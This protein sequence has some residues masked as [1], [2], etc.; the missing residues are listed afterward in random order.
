MFYCMPLWMVNGSG[1]IQSEGSERRHS[2]L[3][4]MSDGS[5]RNLVQIC[6]QPHKCGMRFFFHAYAR[7]ITHGGFGSNVLLVT[8]VICTG[9]IRFCHRLGRSPIKNKKNDGGAYDVKSI[10]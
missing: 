8:W 2:C 6:S 4:G 3:V 9:E 7:P 10:M 5:V 1:R